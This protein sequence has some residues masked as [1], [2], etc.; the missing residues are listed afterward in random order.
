MFVVWH[1]LV[2]FLVILGSPRVASRLSR[3]HYRQALAA[4]FS[5]RLSFKGTAE[6]IAGYGF[7]LVA[8]G[9]ARGRV[10]SGR[11]VSAVASRKGIE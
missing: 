2:S 9:G 10:A 6:E 7:L 5:A 4:I 3:G 1:T 8:E 11:D